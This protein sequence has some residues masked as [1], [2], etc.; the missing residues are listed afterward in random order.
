M[1]LKFE[2][3][4]RII[5]ETDIYPGAGTGSSMAMA[6]TA[7][8]LTGKA[9][10]FSEKVKKLIRDGKFDRELAVKELGDVLW[11]LTAAAHEIGF[12]LQDVAEI[13]TVKLLA[14][15]DK[16]MLQGSGDTREVSEA[17]S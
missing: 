13:N 8:G 4:E 14:R 12:S 10:E 11:Y 16:G 3:Y 17:S 5:A 1:I 15:K 9:G 2:D 7:L 6:Y